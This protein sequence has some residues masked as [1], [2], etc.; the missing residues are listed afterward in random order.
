MDKDEWKSFFRFL[1]QA[2]MEELRK[3]HELLTPLKATVKN[4]EVLSDLKRSLRLLEEEMLIRQR[5]ASRRAAK[6]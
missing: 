1:D 3:R 6:R 5:Q 4:S 2:S